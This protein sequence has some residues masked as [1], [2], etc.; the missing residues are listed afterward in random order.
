MNICDY[1]CSANTDPLCQLSS[2]DQCHSSRAALQ[3]QGKA[4]LCRPCTL[5]A[6]EVEKLASCCQRLIFSFLSHHLHSSCRRHIEMGA[7]I[8]AST[9]AMRGPHTLLCEESHLSHAEAFSIL[10][11]E[12][13]ACILLPHSRH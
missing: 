3:G 5:L 10:K 4:R 11:K 6:V 8:P 2:G 12:N 9:R 13:D 1:L 7:G